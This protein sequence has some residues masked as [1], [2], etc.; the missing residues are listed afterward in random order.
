L[1]ARHE[2]QA[3]PQ[4]LLQQTPSTQEL[5]LGHWLELVQLAPLPTFGVHVPEAQ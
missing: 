1:L 4:A 5:P 2:W 3:V